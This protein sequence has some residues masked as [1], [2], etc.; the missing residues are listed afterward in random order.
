MVQYGDKDLAEQYFKAVKEV[1]ELDERNHKEGMGGFDSYYESS[2]PIFLVSSRELLLP[3]EFAKAMEIAVLSFHTTF[4]SPL[5]FVN[6]KSA[7]SD[8]PVALLV[9]SCSCLKKLRPKRFVSKNFSPELIDNADVPLLMHSVLSSQESLILNSRSSL[10]TITLLESLILSGRLEDGLAFL[11][12]QIV[13]CPEMV[14]LYRY[15]LFS[16][17]NLTLEEKFKYAINYISIASFSMIVYKKAINIA[18][19]KSFQRKSQSLDLLA[20]LISKS[21]SEKSFLPWAHLLGLMFSIK[22]SQIQ[23]YFKLP[24]LFHRDTNEAGILI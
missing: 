21:L 24:K 14:W 5:F 2:N 4:Q 8:S 6:R 20:I 23:H 7:Y 13:A 11:K 10:A 3:S 18:T 19:N 16:P 12:R 15:G 1:F 22:W 9:L 17:F